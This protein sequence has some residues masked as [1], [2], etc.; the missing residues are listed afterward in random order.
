MILRLKLSLRNAKQKCLFYGTIGYIIPFVITVL[1]FSSP[2]YFSSNIFLKCSSL[3]VKYSSSLTSKLCITL[4]NMFIGIAA[5]MVYFNILRFVNV[6]FILQ[7]SPKRYS[8]TNKSGERAGH[9]TFL[10]L[11]NTWLE[12]ICWRTVMDSFATCEVVPNPPRDLFN[13]NFI[14]FRQEIAPWREVWTWRRNNRCLISADSPFLK[15]IF[16]TKARCTTVHCSIFTE[17]TLRKLIWF[18]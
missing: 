11:G 7:I 5:A 2:S 9:R 1:F 4:W 8:H 18:K 3:F 13:D 15:S 14:V 17:T 6:H 12:N 16:T 10:P